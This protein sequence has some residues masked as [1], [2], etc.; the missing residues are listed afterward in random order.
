MTQATAP[1]GQLEETVSW[2]GTRE[3]A[4]ER[5]QVFLARAALQQ[6]GVILLQI[7]RPL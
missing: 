2:T 1:D 3:A 6:A 5:L 4:L 7:R